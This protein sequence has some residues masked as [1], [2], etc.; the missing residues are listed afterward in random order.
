MTAAALLGVVDADAREKPKFKADQIQI[1]YIEPETPAH[2]VVFKLQ[3]EKQALEKL[4]DLLRPMRLPRTLVLQTQSCKG[5]INAFIWPYAQWPVMK[6][7]ALQMLEP[8]QQ[9]LDPILKMVN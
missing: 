5:M 7:Y 3:K 2:Q 1:K 9:I 8:V 4:R 6:V